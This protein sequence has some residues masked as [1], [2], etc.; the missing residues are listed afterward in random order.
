[1]QSKSSG[2]QDHLPWELAGRPAHVKY[3]VL[4]M[5]WAARQ[6]PGEM[7]TTGID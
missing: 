6:F 2:L 7:G 5:G 4:Y 1:M 3:L